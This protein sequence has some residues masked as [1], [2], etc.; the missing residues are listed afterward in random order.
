MKPKVLLAE[1]GSRKGARAKI[2]K[3]GAHQ[4]GVTAQYTK[5][6][7]EKAD[8][9]EAEEASWQ[10]WLCKTQTGWCAELEALLGLQALAKTRKQ[11]VDELKKL[12]SLKIHNAKIERAW[13][14]EP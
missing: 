2:I 11:A 14:D 13:W 12:A 7:L 10:I 8:I 9:A 5:G 3:K 4:V 1:H 6:R